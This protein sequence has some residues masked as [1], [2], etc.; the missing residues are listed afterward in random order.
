MA[1]VSIDMS[2]RVLCDDCDRLFLADSQDVGGMLFESK[3]LCP[4][5][6]PKWELSAKKY[7]EEHFIRDRARDGETFF[8]AV[9]RWREGNNDVRISGDDE[10]V[11]DMQADYSKRI[12]Q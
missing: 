4:H 2:D 3:A 7:G 5:C 1:I 8:A 11:A 6:A 9:M 12:D 10:F